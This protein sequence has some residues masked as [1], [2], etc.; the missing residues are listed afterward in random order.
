MMTGSRRQ[1]LAI[2]GGFVAGAALTAAA[3]LSIREVRRQR[4]LR[5]VPPTIPAARDAE[6]SGWILSASD[7]QAYFTTRD[8]GISGHTSSRGDQPENSGSGPRGSGI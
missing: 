4:Y 5:N 1:F 6:A 7:W 8:G 3:G 2:S